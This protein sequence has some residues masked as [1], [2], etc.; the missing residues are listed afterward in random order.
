MPNLVRNPIAVQAILLLGSALTPLVAALVTP[1]LPAMTRHYAGVEGAEL[2]TRLSLTL[3]GLFIAF[4]APLTGYIIDRY[5]RL[6][7]LTASLVLYAAAGTSSYFLEDLYLLLVGRAIL[8]IAVAGVSTTIYALIG[9]Y[10]EGDT[11]RKLTGLQGAFMTGSGVVFLLVAGQMAKSDWR[12]PYLIYVA[13][14]AFAPAVYFFLREPG[15]EHRKKEKASAALETRQ[16]NEPRFLKKAFNT[17]AII[18]LGMLAYYMIFLQ[19]PYL[20]ES[21][22]MSDPSLISSVVAAGIAGS[23]LSS[24]AFAKLKRHFT[25]RRIYAG[26]FGFVAVG[27]AIVALSTNLTTFI[28]G[29]IL[30]GIGFGL[31]TPNA[32][33]RLMNISSDRARGKIMSGLTTA[34]FLGKFCSPLVV[35]P[36]IA[37]FSFRNVFW[38]AAAFCAVF[39]VGFIVA[40]SRDISESASDT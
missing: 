30:S 36:F 22:G 4:C 27:F 2:L 19:I 17:Y 5:G 13:A 25:F 3:P 24:I 11:R 39:F 38:G 26:V 6:N 18:F 21:A 32:S 15:G 33:L 8:G 10:F 28:I 37:V 31:L 29:V 34:V 12:T 23:A 1:S 7:L 20:M 16:N 9:D 40:F 14:L 35:A